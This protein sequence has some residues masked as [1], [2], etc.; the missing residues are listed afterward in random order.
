[1]NAKPKMPATTKVLFIGISLMLL[2]GAVLIYINAQTVDF[3][4]PT[5]AGRVWSPEHNHWH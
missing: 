3:S 2:A 4:T 5:N 1:M